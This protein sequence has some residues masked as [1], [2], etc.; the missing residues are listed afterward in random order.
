MLAQVTLA[1]DSHT[2]RSVSEHLHSQTL[3]ARA[4]HIPALQLLGD[5]GYLLK[6]QLSCQHNHI[7]PLGVELRRLNIGDI[8]LGGDMHLHTHLA[9]IHN[10][11]HISCD[12]GI[13]ALLYG[14]VDNLT[15][16]LHLVVVKDGIDGE[17]GL[18]ARRVS[19]LHD[20]C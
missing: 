8:A 10:G 13:D 5:R 12:N 17:V 18:H 1:R 3:S 6:T 7:G 19:Y 4:S 20:V 9:T 14:T 15:H 2:Q 16:R 11:C